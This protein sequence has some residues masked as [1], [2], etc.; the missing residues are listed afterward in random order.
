M[1]ESLEY[2]STTAASQTGTFAKTSNGGPA[3]SDHSGSPSQESSLDPAPTQHAPDTEGQRI[4]E[5]SKYEASE[6]FRAKKG[7]RFS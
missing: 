7:D 3:R 5:K 1:Q 4:R 6:P 2:S